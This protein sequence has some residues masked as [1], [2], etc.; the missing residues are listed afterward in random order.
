MKR[1]VAIRRLKRICDNCFC[2]FQKGDVYY[3]KRTV[4]EEDG[5]LFTFEKT[6]CARCK[7]KLEQRAARFEAFKMRCHHPIKEEIWSYIPG[8]AVM[9]PDH[10]ECRVCGQLV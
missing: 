3:Q 10:E 9:Q 6:R 5:E 4:V 2:S 1:K 8:E 7:Y